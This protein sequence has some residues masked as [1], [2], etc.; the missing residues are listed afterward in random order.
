MHLTCYYIVSAGKSVGSSSFSRGGLPAIFQ[1]PGRWGTRSRFLIPTANV[2]LRLCLQAT[3]VSLCLGA[4]ITYSDDLFD[5][6]S[7]PV[8]QRVILFVDLTFQRPA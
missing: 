7:F 8:S 6:F 3:A 5:A 1:N 4:L 2:G